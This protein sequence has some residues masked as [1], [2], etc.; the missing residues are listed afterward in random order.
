MSETA[1]TETEQAQSSPQD[2][3]PT[4]EAASTGSLIA[5]VKSGDAARVEEALAGGADV[6]ETDD[7]GWT[8]LNWAAGRGDAQ[9]VG[10]L[11]EHGAD[12]TRTGRDNRTPERIAKAAG[13]DQVVEMLVEAEKRAGVWQDPRETRPYCRAYPAGRLRAFEGVD[14]APSGSGDSEPVADDDVVFLHQDFTVTRSMWHGED[15]L[16]A[17]PEPAFK[18][19]CRRKLDFSIPDDLL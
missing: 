4:L 2:K 5:L 14:L 9:T 11:L 8:P 3:A 16:L 1:P 13:H 6:H 7:Q 18:D 12:V 10:L 17:E 19:Y 15:V